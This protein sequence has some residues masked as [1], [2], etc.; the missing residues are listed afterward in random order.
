MPVFS[1][2]DNPLPAMVAGA[3]ALA[4]TAGFHYVMATVTENQ[5]AGQVV[6]YWVFSF[7]LFTLACFARQLSGYGRLIYQGVRFAVS[8]AAAPLAVIFAYCLDTGRPVSASAVGAVLQSDATESVQFI[9]NDFMTFRYVTF[10][11]TGFLLTFGCLT[12]FSSATAFF[13]PSLGKRRILVALTLF[14]V[15]FTPYHFRFVSNYFRA[16]NTFQRELDVFRDLSERRA[17]QTLDVSKSGKG[18]LYVVVIG[19]SAGRDMM[20]AYGA[21]VPDTPWMTSMAADQGWVLLKNPYSCDVNT[22]PTVVGAFEQGNQYTGYR[23]PDTVTVLDVCRAAGMRTAWLSNQTRFARWG[24]PITVIAE[25]ADTCLFTNK[26]VGGVAKSPPDSL[27]LPELD[28]VLDSLKRDENTLIV[29]HIVGSH[30]PYSATLDGHTPLMDIPESWRIEQSDALLRARVSAYLTSLRQTDGFL[31][32]VYARLT[33]KAAG[34]PVSFIYFSDHG[35]DPRPGFGHNEDMFT[36]PMA[37]I[38]FFIWS[39]PEYRERYPERLETLKVNKERIVTN[40][41]FFDLFTGLAGISYSG[42]DPSFDLSSE[43]YALHETDARIIK[44]K[45]AV[46]DDPW[47]R[48]RPEGRAPLYP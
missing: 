9:L 21:D 37:R 28:K 8:A 5:D 12:A 36:W 24:T 43:S 30:F 23:F 10:F 19:E 42:R 27:L 3:A 2:P 41:L 31:A 18:E 32:Q 39:S 40:D 25:T 38:P 4:W 20:Q 46:K 33:N 15:L 26:A 22:V 14:A 11:I 6:R 45:K 48:G 29:L 35:E 1:R 44:G 34:R 16:K 7:S 17:G 13:R 47:L